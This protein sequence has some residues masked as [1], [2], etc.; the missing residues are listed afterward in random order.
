MCS[1]I[2]IDDSFTATD[3]LHSHR[4]LSS[5]SRSSLWLLYSETQLGIQQGGV[6]A[7]RYPRVTTIPTDEHAPRLP[8]P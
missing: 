2:N 3:I 5:R 7:V 1:D 6:G 8:T 4:K